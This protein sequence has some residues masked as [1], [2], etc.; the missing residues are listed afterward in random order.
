MTKHCLF[1]FSESR[2]IRFLLFCLMGLVA[3]SI[4]ATVKLPRIFADGMV[5]QREK[6]I[7][8]WGWGDAGQQ[9]SVALMAD[10]PQNPTTSKPQN[11]RTSKPQNLKTSQPHNLKT[12]VSAT[13]IVSAD[14]TWQVTLPAW[15]AMGP[16]QLLVTETAS[17]ESLCLNDVW[18][19]DVWLCSGQSNIDTDVERVY[20][21]YPDEI[22]RDSTTRV[23]LFKVENE[24][25]L[26]GVRNDVRSNGWT[27]LSKNRAWRFSALGYFLGKRMAERTGVVQGVVQS[28]W[29]GTPIESWMTREA[30]RHFDPRMAAEAEYYADDDLRRLSGEVNWRAS[31]RWNQ[32]LDE[33]DPGIKG[34]WMN[35]E[36]NDRRWARANQYQLPVQPVYGFC[37]TYWLRQHIHID[38]AHAGEAA[39][40]LLGTLVDAD[41]TYL[42]GKQVG[43]TGY[44]YPPRRY[45]IPASLLR[46]GDNVLTV[47]FVNRGMRPQFISEKPYRIVWADG[48]HQPLSEEWLV[49][50]G[51]QM[52]NQPSMPTGY[53]NMAAATYNGMLAPL[54]PYAL[55]GV[56]WYQG[57]SNTG[58]AEVY[59]QQLLRMMADWRTLFHQAELPFVIVQLANFMAPSPQ[60]QETGWA[61]LRESQRRAALADPYAELAVAIDLGEANDIHPLRK[62][63]LAERVALC[64]D[65]LVFHSNVLLSPQP[66]NLR[67]SPLGPQG[68]LHSK[69]EQEPHNLTTS[70]SH[71]LTT[72]Q[73]HNLTL[74][75]D[76]PLAEGPVAGFEVADE[77]GKFHNVEALAVGNQVVI[78]ATGQRVRYAWKNNPV[79]ANCRAAKSGLPATPFEMELPQPRYANP[80]LWSDVPDPDVIRVGNEFYMVTTTM[81]LMPGAPIMRS[82]DLVNWQTVGYVFDRLTDSPKYDMREGT[83]YGRGQWATSLKYHKGKFY[84]LFAPNDNPGGDTYICQAERAEGPWSIVSRLR[85]FHDATLFFDDDD[86]VYVFY[87]TGQMC[88]LTADLK[89]VKPGSD[90][91]LFERDA[92]EKGLLESSRVIK[93]NGK[94]YLLMISW[95]GGHP[96]REVCYRAD[97]IRGP[98]EKRVI[99]ETEF[100]GFGGVGQGTIVDDAE[101]N[102]YGM[103][104]Q[105]RGGVGRVLTLEPCRWVDG[106][107]ILG[108][109]KGRIPETIDASWLATL[110][111]VE[112]CSPAQPLT[113][114]DDFS[115]KQLNLNWQ[116]NHNPDN[117]AWSL[118]ERAGWLRLRTSRVVE[119]M[120]AAPNSI[121]QR[122]EGPK[123][124]AT[125]AM[126]I[127]KLK[128]GDRAGFAAFN[129]HS[130]VLTVCRDGGETYL[131]LTEQLVSLTDREKQI[132][133]VDVEEKARVKLKAKKV[134]LR[135]D[136]D[137]NLHRDK[138]TFFYS[139]DGKQWQSLGGEFQMR[140]DY[141]RLFMGTRYQIFCYATKQPGGWVDVDSFSY[142]R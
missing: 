43:H 36:L 94:Y 13:A 78:K 84:A 113:L 65:K 73:P 25:V 68:R 122:M 83:V 92:D 15:K 75:F 4:Q 79:E 19:G 11:L 16:L 63:E 33:S 126:D 109:E 108:D 34:G 93:H 128:D 7:T 130:G 115:K 22:D 121:S 127:A 86:R 26:E 42:N 9:I 139:L 110:K 24:A 114:S 41:F 104:F 57:E 27:T 18:V 6:P 125:V 81:H 87:G 49:H 90:C 133:K 1:F 52:P 2:T 102:W 56:V 116:W 5:L 134:W 140:F 88:E 141:T 136:G 37:G 61:R 77:K 124:S 106:W 138:A 101:G 117:E 129:G 76:Q 112:D 60:P 142:S 23:R 44:Q 66:Q 119:N 28:S 46:E 31:Q 111:G 21:Q 54:A 55:A 131:T 14:G 132:T 72:S 47:R 67:T 96:R 32:L 17:G 8:V 35:A 105:D 40:L 118:T 48:T 38:A 89:D 107:P 100:A 71:N 45:Q 39:Q 59:E 98:Y 29:G 80:V 10:K 103:I 20:P 70:Q 85:H 97:N 120:Y 30:V 135:I 99:L 74:T 82:T 50:D 3:L 64:F 69:A 95:T 51:T 62:K 58:R 137:F 91:R 123:C 12:I 53:Q